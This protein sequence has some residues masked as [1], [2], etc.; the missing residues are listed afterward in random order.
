M[1]TNEVEKNN[2]PSLQKNYYIF[3]QL[4]VY[5]LLGFEFVDIFSIYHIYIRYRGIFK[6]YIVM[7]WHTVHFSS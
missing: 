6:E 4:F 3:A 7:I 2:V 1:N 5:F